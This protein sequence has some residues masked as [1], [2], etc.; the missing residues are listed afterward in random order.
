MEKYDPNSPYHKF[1]T[2]YINNEISEL[3][4]E[5]NILVKKRL[6]KDIRKSEELGMVVKTPI[7]EKEKEIS[8]KLRNFYSLRCKRKKAMTKTTKD[9]C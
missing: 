7:T 3:L 4:S 8:K 2:D 5:K 1:T 9:D 6:R